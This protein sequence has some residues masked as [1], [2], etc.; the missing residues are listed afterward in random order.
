MKQNIQFEKLSND[1]ETKV[2]AGP[3]GEC[4]QKTSQSQRSVFLN[5]LRNIGALTIQSNISY[6]N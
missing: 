1:N 4:L 6:Y 5:I 3:T 2:L